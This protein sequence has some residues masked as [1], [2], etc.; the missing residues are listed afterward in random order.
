MMIQQPSFHRITPQ[1]VREI[2]PLIRDFYAYEHRPL[3]ENRV[4]GAL[5]ILAGNAQLGNA[6]M[7]RC[8]NELVGYLVL[9]Y[10]F[11]LEFGGRDAFIDEL[12]IVETHRGRGIGKEALK[13]AEWICYDEN[14]LA[15]HL[16]VMDD[17]P[18]AYELYRKSGFEARSSRMM[19][20]TPQA[21]E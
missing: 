13:F 15:L 14:V 18:K 3:D 6:W 9:C 19:T 8:E 4:V 20:K 17:N 16:E 10:G 5:E 2:A 12:F 21:S 7:I 11:S 1:Q